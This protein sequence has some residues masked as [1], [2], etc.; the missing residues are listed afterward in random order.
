[1]S[2]PSVVKAK[3]FLMN[4]IV[5]QAKRA[6]VP[7]TEV[8]TRM[9]GFSPGSASPA[10]H[11]AAAAFDRAYDKQKYE[12]KV[13]QLF[14]DVYELDKS[15]GRAE[16]WEQSLDSLAQENI[17]LADIIRKSGLRQAT[18]P[19]YL[20]DLRSLRQYFTAIIMVLAGI[21]VAFTPL[22]ERLVPDPVLR[23]FVVLCFWLT[24]WII[25]KLRKG[26]GE[27]EL[28]GAEPGA[29]EK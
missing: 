25:S 24:P 6:N 23:T 7:L 18:V 16:V 28:G 21:V 29:Q 11:Q 1:M 15:L 22:G 10:E 12:T 8:E 9:L 17:Y 19:W 20:P 5:D 14:R 3:R 2:S 13:S 4:R 27:E 26:S